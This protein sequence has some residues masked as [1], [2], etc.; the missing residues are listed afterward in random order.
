MAS[1]PSPTEKEKDAERE[2]GK[3]R[4][5]EHRERE[6]ERELREREKEREREREKE[7]EKERERE[8]DRERERERARE[9]AFNR[10]PVIAH[11]SSKTDH[12]ASIAALASTGISVSS[13]PPKAHSTARFVFPPLVSF[14]RLPT[15][16]QEWPLHI[17][18]LIL[19]HSVTHFNP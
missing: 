2:R 14:P 12:L 7:R 13:V 10:I 3:E 18:L 1:T 11:S 17:S 8:R 5:R 4:E 9:M 6:R 15:Y 19:A 16:T